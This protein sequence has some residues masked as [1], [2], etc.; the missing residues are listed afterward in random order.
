MI[1]QKNFF[2]R[3]KMANRIWFLFKNIRKSVDK[4]VKIRENK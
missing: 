4:N 1:D 3:K 2:M